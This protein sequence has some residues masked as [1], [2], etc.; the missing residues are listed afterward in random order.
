MLNNNQK[1]DIPE[2]EEVQDPD[3]PDFWTG[4]NVNFKGLYP[5]YT[6][7]S[8]YGIGSG[9]FNFGQRNFLGSPN[10]F[11]PYDENYNTNLWT[12]RS[13]SEENFIA[14]ENLSSARYLKSYSSGQYYFEV[15]IGD[16]SVSD[17]IG[18]SENSDIPVYEQDNTISVRRIGTYFSNKLKYLNNTSSEW[19]TNLEIDAGD[20]VQVYLDYDNNRFLIKSLERTQ[21]PIALLL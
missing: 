1:I 9:D 6:D 15:T 11:L 18:L 2:E 19:A 17:A 3:G 13:L 16:T 20:T 21:T 5:N 10:G 8:S 14:P 12:G 4:I 7:A